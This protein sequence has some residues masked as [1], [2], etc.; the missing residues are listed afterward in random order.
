MK[1]PHMP[2]NEPPPLSDFS[3]YA[4]IPLPPY[5]TTSF[6]ILFMFYYVYA[7]KVLIPLS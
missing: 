6:I 4:R 1:K 7:S 5:H 2:I 3:E